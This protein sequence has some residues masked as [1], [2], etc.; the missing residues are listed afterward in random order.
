LT[1]GGRR[2]SKMV[3]KLYHVFFEQLLRAVFFNLFVVAEPK[4]PSKKFAEPYMPPQN[5]L[6]NP[7]FF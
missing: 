2:G 6:R 5:F 7:N 3:Q 1:Q 4:M